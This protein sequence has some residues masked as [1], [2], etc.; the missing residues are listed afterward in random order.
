M[1]VKSKFENAV[2]FD[3]IDAVRRLVG[4]DLR[5]AEPPFPSFAVFVCDDRQFR[6]GGGSGGWKSKGAGN[7]AGQ[8]M[9]AVLDAQEAAGTCRRLSRM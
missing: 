6:A 3:Q 5:S 7:D 1:Q 9:T 4:F 2:S 8:A